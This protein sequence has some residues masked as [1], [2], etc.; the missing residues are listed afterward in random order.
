MAD[1][2]INAAS[3]DT[4]LQAQRARRAQAANSSDEDFVGFRP[5]TNQDQPAPRAGA[6]VV[7]L[8]QSAEIRAH[9]QTAAAADVTRPDF[10]AIREAVKNGT[11]QVDPGAL[12]QK[13]L[14]DPEA[15]ALLFNE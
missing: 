3:T 11:Y 12:A 6:D 10:E 1:K 13:M 4:A 9:A 14:S 15:A 7:Q 2:T 8:G 5:H